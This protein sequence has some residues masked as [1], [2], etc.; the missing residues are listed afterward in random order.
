VAI[1]STGTFTVNLTNVDSLTVVFKDHLFIGANPGDFSE[2]TT[3]GLSI[4]PK[5]TC[6]ITFTF[7]PQATGLRTAQFQIDDNDASSPQIL[8]FSGTGQ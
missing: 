8:S 3:C 5:A 6:T 4:L 2:T 1:G 7:T